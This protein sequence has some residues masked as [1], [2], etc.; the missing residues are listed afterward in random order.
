L[1][2]KYR[3]GLEIDKNL[4]KGIHWYKQAAEQGHIQALINLG[5]FY[6]H[7]SQGAE[8][9]T[10]LA[11]QMYRRAADQ[12]NVT[13]QCNLALMYNSG[14]GVP[15]DVSQARKW[16]KIA[17]DKGNKQAQSHLNILERSVVH[18][19]SATITNSPIITVSTP[20]IIA[21][22]PDVTTSNLVPAQIINKSD[23]E[24]ILDTYQS[25]SKWSC[26]SR[27]RSTVIKELRKLLNNLVIT[28]DNIEKA[29]LKDRYASRRFLLFSHGLSS[30]KNTTSTDDVI[31]KL[32]LKFNG[33]PTLRSNK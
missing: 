5:F 25:T 32:F 23:F 16:F 31:H 15:K 8:K 4:I 13:A 1:A 28:K 11:A 7:G 18:V 3:K 14:R 30:Q 33:E 2:T 19:V 29:I 27:Y 22:A 20:A 26:F 17:A 9:N 24:E 10:V 21:S 12:G 6:E